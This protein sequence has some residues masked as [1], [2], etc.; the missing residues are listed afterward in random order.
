MPCGPNP[1]LFRTGNQD[2][3]IMDILLILALVVLGIMVNDT[4]TW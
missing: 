4:R 3:R 1:I 2:H